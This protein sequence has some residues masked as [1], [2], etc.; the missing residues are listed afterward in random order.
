MVVGDPRRRYAIVG[1]GHRAEMFLKA[2]LEDHAEFANFV[3]WC[4]TNP[5]RMKYYDAFLDEAGVEPARHYLA[6]QLEEMILRENIDAVIVTSPDFTHADIVARS[7]HAGADVVVEKPLTTTA[8]GCEQ[9]SAAV[10]ETGRDLVMTFNYRYS[11]R[12][13]TLKQVIAS[14]QIG[15]PTSI[16]FEWMLD[17]VHGADYFRRWH[18]DK[19]KSGGLLVHKSSHHFDLANWWLDD[20]PDVVVAL[21]SR[22][23][24]GDDAAGA[25][26]A[27]HRPERGTESQPGDPWS[28]DL[29]DDRRLAKLYLETEKYDGYLR[30]KDVFAP[31]VTIEDTMSVLV[32]YSRGAALTYSLTAYSPWE[33]YRV[34]VNGTEG[35]AEL[36]VVERGAIALDDQG[37]AV[38]DPS[39]TNVLDTDYLRPRGERLVVQQHWQPAREVA[40]PMG[41]GSHGGGDAILLADIYR[42]ASADPLNRR[43]GYA[44]GIHAVS[45]GIAA[46]KSIKTQ[47]VVSIGSLSSGRELV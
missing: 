18:R 14:G 20:T 16:H 44:D 46:N 37:R 10:A 45:V 4:D 25:L 19:Q 3:A 23:F 41:K 8:E 43:A 42:G 24:Y 26:L 39:A 1:M 11:P 31:G 2:G 35:R 33:G 38:L 47:R 27:G 28:L 29:S 9:I 36:E 32:G 21:G 22:Q 15:H 34:S 6:S 12:N 40:I 7:L 17:T 5:G 13:S 30:D